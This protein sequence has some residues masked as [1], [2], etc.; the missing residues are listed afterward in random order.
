MEFKFEFPCGT[1][2]Y[3]KV[4]LIAAIVGDFKIDSRWGCPLHGKKCRKK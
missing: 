2:I 4:S 3:E 1:I